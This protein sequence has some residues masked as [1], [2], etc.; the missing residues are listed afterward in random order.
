MSSNVGELVGVQH[1]EWQVARR[2]FSAEFMALL[3]E[4]KKVEATPLL[5]AS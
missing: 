5:M 1:D 2:Y 3:D 4:R